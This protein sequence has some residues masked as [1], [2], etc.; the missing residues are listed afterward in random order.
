MTFLHPSTFALAQT[1]QIVVPVARRDLALQQ[2]KKPLS[3]RERGSR[4]MHE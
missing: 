3:L 2:E 1:P 4:V